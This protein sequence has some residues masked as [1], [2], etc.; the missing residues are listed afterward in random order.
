[1]N[2]LLQPESHR[3]RRA[4]AL[5]IRRTRHTDVGGTKLAKGEYPKKGNQWLAVTLGK[6]DVC[7]GHRDWGKA[8]K[9]CL[10]SVKMTP[11]WTR[12]QMLERRPE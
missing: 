4:A 1:M 8:L 5:R 6:G 12:L 7:A 11:P 10:L 9:G 2:H 3:G